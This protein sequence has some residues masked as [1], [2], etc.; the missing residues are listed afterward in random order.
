MK[1]LIN[2]IM[3]NF[4][5]VVFNDRLFFFVFIFY[6]FLVICCGSLVLGCVMF[7]VCVL[8][9]VLYCGFVIVFFLWLLLGLL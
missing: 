8:I 3:L 4:S 2:E 1:N 5:V 7:K 9:L 6:I